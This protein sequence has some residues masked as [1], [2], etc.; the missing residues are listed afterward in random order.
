MRTR[1][2]FIRYY[3]P[4]TPARSLAGSGNDGPRRRNWESD[5]RG[6]ETG[7]AERG[8]PGQSTGKPRKSPGEASEKPR[9][10][11]GRT[12]GKPR[13]NLGPPRGASG[14]LGESRERTLRQNG[15]G[16]RGRGPANPGFGGAQGL[17]QRFRAEYLSNTAPKRLSDGEGKARFFKFFNIFLVKYL[18]RIKIR[19]IFALAIKERRRSLIE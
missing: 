19:S 18:H 4:R 12:P 2:S 8:C 3:S 10:S 11:P 17:I 15:G 6:E 5:P 1:F 7:P 9:E 14:S 16:R 13:E